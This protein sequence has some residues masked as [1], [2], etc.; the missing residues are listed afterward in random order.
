MSKM[1]KDLI[2]HNAKVAKAIREMAI[3]IKEHEIRIDMVTK[4]KSQYL[5]DD[6]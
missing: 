1:S 4:A 3:E 2:R 5:G 6:V